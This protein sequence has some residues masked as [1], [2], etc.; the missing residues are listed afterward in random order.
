MSW[1]Y[2]WSWI[3]RLVSFGD[4]NIHKMPASSSFIVALSLCLLV[5]GRRGLAQTLL[6]ALEKVPKE[7][8]DNNKNAQPWEIYRWAQRSRNMLKKA[9]YSFNIYAFLTKREVKMS[10]YWPCSFFC[11]CVRAFFF[12]TDRYE[13]AD[14]NA[15][16]KRPVST[17]LDRT[18]SVNKGFIIWPTT[19]ITFSCRTNAEKPERARRVFVLIHY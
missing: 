4:H 10:G 14:K 1:C 2:S 12:V 17:N 7:K 6:Y 19:R 8:N 5:R 13:V 11:F 3:L 15:K 16:E 18:T 9:W